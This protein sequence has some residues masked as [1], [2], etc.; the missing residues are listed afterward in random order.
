MQNSDMP[1]KD[2]I[3][4]IVASN[5]D[6]EAREMEIKKMGKAYDEIAEGVLP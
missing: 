3:L 1:Q 4:R 6:A 5:S 2:M